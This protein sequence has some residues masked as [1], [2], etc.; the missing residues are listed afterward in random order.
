MTL[1]QKADSHF[2]SFEFEQAKWFYMQALRAD[3]SSP[4]ILKSNVS[5]CFFEMGKNYFLKTFFQN[6]IFILILKL[7]IK[8][9]LREKH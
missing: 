4:A 8:R 7:L 3:E 1:K 9:R 2:K 6:F 5:A